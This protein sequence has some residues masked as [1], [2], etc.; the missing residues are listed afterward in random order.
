MAAFGAWFELWL[1][2]ALQTARLLESPVSSL[3]HEL[4]PGNKDIA[5]HLLGQCDQPHN[6]V[7]PNDTL[8]AC[9]VRHSNAASRTWVGRPDQISDRLHASLVS[10]LLRGAEHG[11]WGPRP[12]LTRLVALGGRAGRMPPAVA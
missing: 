7:M 1:E 9:R 2:R 8:P 10:R 4:L 5:P 3:L 12:R 6:G 11:P